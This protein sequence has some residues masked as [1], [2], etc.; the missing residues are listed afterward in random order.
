MRLLAPLLCLLLTAREASAYCRSTTC[1]PQKQDCEV[2]EAGCKTA[3]EPLAWVSGCVGFSLSS[4]GSK[5]I[6]FEPVQE[7]FDAALAAWSEIDCGG[8]F[9]SISY[10][11]LDDVLCGV[12]YNTKGA[13]ANVLVFRDNDWPYQGITNTLGYTTVTFSVASGQIL[14]TD[15]EVNTAQNIITTG[16]E[17]PVYDLQSILT[18]ELGHALGLSHTL[19]SDA[20]MRASYDKGTIEL[21]FL[22]DDDREAICEAYPPGRKS[23]CET[24]P[25]GGFSPCNTLAPNVS[26]P[27]TPSCA[28]GPAGSLSSVTLLLPLAALVRARRRRR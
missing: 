11:R 5:N 1:N 9:A 4:R 3:G 21:R 16:N 20:T 15:I 24:D 12:E 22:G 23:K 25:P 8:E 7:A 19:V 6:K 17:K 10:G 28:W 18:H 2:D 26:A 27:S 14:G 13:N